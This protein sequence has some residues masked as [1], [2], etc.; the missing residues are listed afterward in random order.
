MIDLDTSLGDLVLADPRRARVLEGL[1]LDYC[2]HGQRSL[3]DAAA[4]AGLDA[5]GV[6]QRL[7]LPAPDAAPE[8]QSLTEAELADHIVAVHHAYLWDE[9]EPLRA[10]VDKVATVHGERHPELAGVKAD[11]DALADDL[12]QHLLKEE[13]ILFPAI[14]AAAEGQGFGPGVAGPIQ[15]MMMEHDAAGEILVRLRAAT[16]GYTTPA[17]GCA[18]YH[19]MMDRLQIMEADLHLH[20]HKENNVLFPRTLA[21]AGVTV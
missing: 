11:Y 7:D 18:S 19:S 6:A 3:A 5:P 8:W 13:R 15:V 17:D 1:G 20:I 16:D 4:E 10:L 14:R 12:S 9:L 2:C 21:A